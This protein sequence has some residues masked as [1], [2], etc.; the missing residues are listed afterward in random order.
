MLRSF[1]DEMTEEIFHGI[2][3]HA[4]RKKLSTELVHAAERKLDLLNCIHSMDDLKK[5]PINK[6]EGAPVRDVH[7]KYSFPIYENWR[8]AFRW[9]NDGAEDVQLLS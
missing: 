8:I 1:G 7:G 9:N 4:L 2:H 3:T 6:L 5:L